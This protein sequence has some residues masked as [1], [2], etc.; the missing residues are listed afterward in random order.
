MFDTAALHLIISSA[1]YARVCV[2]DVVTARAVVSGR[3]PRPPW[4]WFRQRDRL[5]SETEL[6][7][8]VVGPRAWNSLPQSSP[9]HL[10]APLENISRPIYFH[11][12]FTA[13]D[14]SLL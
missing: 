13:R 7:V 10:L 3:H 1:V 4:W 9:A 5:R 12:H 8:A 6:L 14:S 11:Y 2:V